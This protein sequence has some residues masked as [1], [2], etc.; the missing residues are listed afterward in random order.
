MLSTSKYQLSEFE[1]YATF[2]GHNYTDR[3]QTHALGQHVVDMPD[4]SLQDLD[5]MIE[6]LRTVVTGPYVSANIIEKSYDAAQ[7]NWITFYTMIKDKSW[8]DC[9]N[10]DD[11]VKLPNKIQQECIDNFGY[12][13]RWL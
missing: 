13:P 7:T 2:V 3:Y 9:F 4:R 11:F 1:T 8:P 6:Y 5:T 10:E 12:R